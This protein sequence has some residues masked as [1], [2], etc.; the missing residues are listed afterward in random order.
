MVYENN[1]IQSGTRPNLFES[2][3]PSVREETNSYDDIKAD[4]FE[5]DEEENLE[6]KISTKSPKIRILTPV[7][8]KNIDFKSIFNGADFKKMF[9]VP[10]VKDPTPDYSDED[11]VNERVRKLIGNSN[12]VD[13]SGEDK[14]VKEAVLDA[15]ENKYNTITE[16]YPDYTLKFNR[17]KNLNTIHKNYHAVVRSIFAHM[18]VGQTQ[19]GYILVLLVMEVI[20]IKVFNL[21]MA[22][23]TKMEMKRMFKYNALMIEIGEDMY[24]S[25]GEGEVQDIKWRIGTAMLWNI[26]IFLGI[27]LLSS[28]MGG[29]GMIDTVRTIVDKLFENNI[30]IDNIES[31]EAKKINEEEGELF[32]GLF[33]SGADGT[34]ELADFISSLGSSFTQ[35]MENS[36]KGPRPR[37][38][39]RVIFDD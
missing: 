12:N 9:P 28:Y 14:R 13:Y 37:N 15:F 39:S 4:L 2:F 29:D 11:E 6:E 10:H 1:F 22:G 18:N 5:D 3:S 24:S 27:K 31:G 20:F 35:G 19:M 25:G 32:S 34:S 17:D 26:V 21:P 33:D 30:N 36:R 8:K 23:F 38:K 7:R 16:K